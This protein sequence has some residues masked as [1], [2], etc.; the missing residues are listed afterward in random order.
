MLGCLVRGLGVAGGARRA[1]AGHDELVNISLTDASA[2]QHQP[3]SEARSCALHL[4]AVGFEYLALF[5]YLVEEEPVAL[6]HHKMP[7]LAQVG[8]VNVLM[9]WLGWVQGAFC[10]CAIYI[11]KH[12][13]VHR[14]GHPP[15]RTLALEADLKHT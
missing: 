3:H 4:Q 8:K 5:V 12:H 6:H 10:D 11:H 13:G 2:S 1:S 15:W 7:L 14:R 9:V